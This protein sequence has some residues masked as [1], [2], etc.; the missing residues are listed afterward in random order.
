MDSL[1]LVIA[2]VVATTVTY[3]MTRILDRGEP[4]PI[5]LPARI[6]MMIVGGIGATFI[7]Y[8]IAPL[9]L[10]TVIAIAVLVPLI[11]FVAVIW[12][13]LAYS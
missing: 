10:F 1:I 6:T 8:A 12:L 9:S 5:G 4:Q 7:V 2:L 13:M 3:F 11:L